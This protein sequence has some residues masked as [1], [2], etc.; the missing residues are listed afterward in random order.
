[1]SKQPVEELHLL[2]AGLSNA[3]AMAGVSQDILRKHI[4]SGRLP[5]ARPSHCWVVRPEDLAAWLEEM[6]NRRDTEDQ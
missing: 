1:M 6:K 5:A 4:H 2:A 3:S